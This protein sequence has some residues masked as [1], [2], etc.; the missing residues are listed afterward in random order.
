MPLPLCHWSMIAA[1]AL[2]PQALPPN[3]NVQAKN[4]YRQENVLP[5]LE[6]LARIRDG[7]EPSPCQAA[8]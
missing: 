6:R 2:T 7:K 3:S 1:L 4:Y 5:D 8:N